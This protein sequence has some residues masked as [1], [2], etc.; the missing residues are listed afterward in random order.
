MQL[1]PIERA[2]TNSPLNPGATVSYEVVGLPW[3]EL[4]WIALTDT[5][6]VLRS[7]NG[8]RGSWTGAHASEHAALLALGVERGEELRRD[9]EDRSPIIVSESAVELRVISVGPVPG[10]HDPIAVRVHAFDRDHGAADPYHGE[11]IINESVNTTE[12]LGQAIVHRMRRIVLGHI[13]QGAQGL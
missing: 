11:F 8:V 6:Q 9:V 1:R 7:V 10:G 3:N 13:P 12:E 2:H 5:W 4:A